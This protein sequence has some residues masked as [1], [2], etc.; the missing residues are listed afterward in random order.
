[1]QDDWMI[2]HHFSLAKETELLKG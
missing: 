1:M 2:P